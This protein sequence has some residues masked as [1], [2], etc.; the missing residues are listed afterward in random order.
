MSWIEFCGLLLAAGKVHWTDSLKQLQ[1]P[2]VLFGFSAQA[3]FASRFVVQWIASER[4]G[5]SYVPVAF[6]YLSIAGTLL[7]AVYAFYRRDPVFILGQTLNTFIYFRN[8]MLIYR[9]KARAV[10]AQSN[11]PVVAPERADSRI[12]MNRPQTGAPAA[13]VPS[14]TV[15]TVTNEA[16]PQTLP[17]QSPPP[18]RRE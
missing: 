3:L 8:L 12:F 11:L 2:W 14:A 1:D 6:W 16:K 18:P 7:L 5:L 17:V 13:A 15:T 4:R 9:P 10:V